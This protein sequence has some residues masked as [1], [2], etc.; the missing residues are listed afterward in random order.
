MNLCT[1]A[2]VAASRQMLD[3][4]RDLVECESPSSDLAAVSRSADV[5]AAIGARLL[6]VTPE[7]IIVDGCTHLRWTLGR[8][9]DRVLLLGHH[10]TVWP[11]G[12]LATR[13]WS[14]S[15]GVMRGPGTFDMKV[16]VVMALHAAARVP[17]S[18]PITILITGDEEIGSTTSRQLILDEANRCRTALVLEAAGDEGALKTARKGISDYQ[19]EVKGRAAHAGLEP[20]NGVNAAVELAHQILAIAQ[21]GSQ[22]H[23]TSVVPT[24]TS[25][26][27][28]TNTVPASATLSVDVRAWSVVEQRRVDQEMKALKPVLDAAVITVR[29]GP[30]RPP[31]DEESSRLVFQLACEVADEL[32]LPR[33]EQAHV[34]G[35]S[36]GNFTASAGT[37][38]LD[39]LGAVGGGAHA[40]HEHVLIEEI[41]RRTALLARLIVRLTG[42]VVP[43][44]SSPPIS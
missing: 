15:D 16:G 19:V 4:I 8:G 25:A 31:L 37:P 32:G 30:N 14:I 28:T 33:L 22:E 38:T 17:R 41:P 23:G 9:R 10:D 1:D 39:G 18:T 7:R 6:G 12:S 3:D 35:A 5:V 11:I 13:P 21:L 36:D 42:P 29:G 24:V 27:T 20:E 40:E 2:S 44:E 34:G 26:G 43:D